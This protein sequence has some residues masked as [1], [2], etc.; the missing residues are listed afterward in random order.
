MFDFYRLGY[1]FNIFPES[2]IREVT[3][4]EILTPK[5]YEKIVGKPYK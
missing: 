4:L 1:E 3:D 2:E 5:E